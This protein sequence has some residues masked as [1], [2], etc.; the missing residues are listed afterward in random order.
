M[1][2]WDLAHDLKSVLTHFER[3]NPGK[4]SEEQCE[5]MIGISDTT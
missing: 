3:S 2:T 4:S 5:D 1:H